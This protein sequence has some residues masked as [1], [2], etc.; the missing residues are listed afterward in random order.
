L[1][2][3][4]TR[5]TWAIDHSAM[6]GAMVATPALPATYAARGMSVTNWKPLKPVLEKIP[7]LQTTAHPLSQLLRSI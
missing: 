7:P 5:A 4:H 3:R 1:K 6:L 2:K